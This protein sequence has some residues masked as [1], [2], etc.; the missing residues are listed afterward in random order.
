MTRVL[1]VFTIIVIGLFVYGW[2]GEAKNLI[3]LISRLIV[4]PIKALREKNRHP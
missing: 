4:E 1:I 3:G 2:I